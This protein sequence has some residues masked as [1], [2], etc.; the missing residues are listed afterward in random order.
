[1]KKLIKMYNEKYGDT[2]G[3]I[4][5]DFNKE[6]MYRIYYFIKNNCDDKDIQDRIKMINLDKPKTLEQQLTKLESE[7]NKGGTDPTIK[8]DIANV[9]GEVNKL[10]AQY[11]DITNNVYF[12]KTNT[13]SELVSILNDCNENA[14]INLLPN[15]V[16]EINTQINIHKNITMNFNGSKFNVVGCE[17]YPNN[18]VISI[19]P[20][21]DNVIKLTQLNYEKN[22]NKIVVPNGSE[23]SVGE[24][25]FISMGTLEYD[26]SS[27]DSWRGY[28]TITQI[29]NNTITIDRIA[30]TSIK[31]YTENINASPEND[32]KKDFIYKFKNN[33]NSITLNDVNINVK[34]DL[35]LLSIL[36]IQKSQNIILHN[37]VAINNS[38]FLYSSECDNTIIDNPN[39]HVG[40]NGTIDS[41]RFLS[42]VN[43]RNIIVNNPIIYT[44][45][46]ISPI[47][48]ECCS[49]LLINNLIYFNNCENTSNNITDGLVYYSGKSK[50]TINHANLVF[51]NSGENRFTKIPREY[52]KCNIILKNII[53]NTE[54]LTNLYLD[55]VDDLYLD[56]YDLQ[57]KRVKF[58]DVKYENTTTGLQCSS[59]KLPQGVYSKIGI[60][61]DNINSLD[62]GAII[63]SSGGGLSFDISS[64]ENDKEVVYYFDL[65]GFNMIQL[66]KK[67]DF[68]VKASNSINY[69]VFLEYFPI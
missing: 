11:K 65:N 62:S 51:K 64:I 8:S 55:K 29:D 14:I 9:K 40:T 6:Q 16:Y 35:V 48:A 1:M 52:Q 19:S 57:H 25:I 46:N 43:S 4:D 36:N 33:I 45:S 60:E 69:K 20:T 2:L 38:I 56:G 41:F 63:N 49:E 22:S 34:S 18:N 50:I 54:I 47:F 30:D 10:N 13:Q 7:N 44:Q 26:S 12:L 3:V 53:L 61:I 67:I 37:P 32:K 15:E 5:D 31:P 28:S 42:C 68:Y 59:L 17:S 24:I 39:I 66:D 21:I 23:F 58:I 27:S